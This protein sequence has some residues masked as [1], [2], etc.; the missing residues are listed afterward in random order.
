MREN[1]FVCFLFPTKKN[2]VK[3]KK[4]NATTLTKMHVFV[5]HTCLLLQQAE[6]RNTKSKEPGSLVEVIRNQLELSL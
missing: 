1:D 4:R 2:I 6:T 5:L 3:S